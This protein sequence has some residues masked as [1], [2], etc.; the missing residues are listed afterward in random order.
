MASAVDIF[1]QGFFD[2]AAIM[3]AMTD[4][5]RKGLARA[6]YRVM[7]K[8]RGSMK[9]KKGPAPPGS[10]PHVHQGQLKSLLFFAYDVA[11]KS[12]VVGPVGFEGSDVPKV[13]EFGGRKIEKRPYMRP[14]MASQVDTMPKLIRFG[15]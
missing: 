10:P 14:A 4:A 3:G 12:T 13:L 11:A 15:S 6:G 7:K 8:A 9:K 2:R 5:E 1:K